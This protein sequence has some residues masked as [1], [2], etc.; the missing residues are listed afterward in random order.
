MLACILGSISDRASAATSLSMVSKMASRSAGPSSST[1]SAR[2]A[3]CRRSS[4]SFEMFSRRR[5]RGSASTMLQ[6]SQRIELGEIGR[7]RW[8]IQ[9]GGTIPCS[10]RRR[11]LRMPDVHFEHHER[12]ALVRATSKTDVGDP[13]HLPAVDVDNLLVEKIALNAQH[14]LVRVVRIQF[15]VAELNAVERNGRDLIVTDGKPGRSGADQIPVN[16]RRMNQRNDGG[17]ADPPDAPMFQVEDWQAEKIRE[18]EEV[19]RHRLAPVDSSCLAYRQRPNASPLVE[20]AEKRKPQLSCAL[21][22]VRT[23]DFNMPQRYPPRQEQ[24]LSLDLYRKRHHPEHPSAHPYPQSRI[25]PG[26]AQRRQTHS[27]D[28][29][30]RLRLGA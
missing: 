11:M 20:T 13:D 17:V 22:R 14:V 3:G 29:R 30:F 4:F 2:S 12:I 1:M 6:N 28:H 9:R 15:F 18:V 26:I 27:R 5:R 23:S 10:N 24:N 8:R 16:P 21:H 19:F 7:C 25:A